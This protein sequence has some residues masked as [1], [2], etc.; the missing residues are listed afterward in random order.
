[1][2]RWLQKKISWK[3]ISGWVF[4]VLALL[5]IQR[6]QNTGYFN[7]RSKMWSDSAGYY[8][9]SPALFI[10]RFDASD[11]PENIV[12]K[13]G[14]GFTIN[15]K[16]KI[17]TRYSYGV[18]LLQSP[19]FF[20]IHFMVDLTGQKQD[21]F[22]GIYHFVSSLSALFYAFTG[23]LLLW[24]FLRYY[25]SKII[26]FLSIATIFLGTNLIYYTIDATGMSHIYSFFLFSALLLV[27]KKFYSETESRN[28][29]MYFILIA[30]TS[31]LIV[32][33][34]PTNLAFIG[35]AFLLDIKSMKEFKNRL[36]KVFI[37]EY[38]LMAIVVIL[39]V[40]SP[41]LLYWKYASGSYITNPYKGYGFS[42]WASPQIAEF[43][44]SPNNGLFPYN[45]IYFIIFFALFYMIYK[46]QHNGYYI[47]IIFAGLIYL[48]SSWFIFSFG[49]GFGSRNFVE[50]TTIFALPLGYLFQKSALKSKQFR[51]IFSIIILFFILINLKLVSAYDKCFLEGEWDFKE[52]AYFLKSRKCTRRIL[53]S[54]KQLLTPAKEFSKG[55]RINLKNNTLVNYRKAFVSVDAKIYDPNIEAAIVATIVSNDSTIYWNGYPLKMGYDFNRLGEKQRIKADFWFSRYYTVKSELSTFIWNMGKDSLEISEFKIRLE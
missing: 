38:L 23:L 25:F 4:I 21:G 34:R 16:G 31:A 42:N 51:R 44:F 39:M 37:P 3:I 53:Y 54:S 22:S 45:P 41:Q 48:F 30:F 29:S 7:W 26:A 55:I 28:K 33:I 32:L 49:C 14:K 1:M 20:A 52:Y 5:I 46:K 17:V 2:N 43:L 36:K 13:T 8:I 50:Y 12:E 24:R 18:A 9:Y 19:F 15:E 47:L 35:L 40:F 10:Y 11:L 6:H 27:S